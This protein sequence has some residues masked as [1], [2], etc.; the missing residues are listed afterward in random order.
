MANEQQKIANR[1]RLW[2]LTVVG[3]TIGIWEMVEETSVALSPQIGAQI[4]AMAE[5]QLGLEIAGEKPEHLLVELGRIFVDE[6]GYASEIK[7]EGTDK[8]FRVFLENV[9]G[10]PETVMMKERGVEKA[11]SNPFFCAGLAALARLGLKVRGSLDID[12]ANRRFIVTY[13]VI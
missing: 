8:T 9:V 6:Y 7:V 10:F 5:K 2:G 4:L 1:A 13:E 11:F 12:V 3:M